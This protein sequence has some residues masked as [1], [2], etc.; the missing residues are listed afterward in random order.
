MATKGGGYAAMRKSAERYL[1][2]CHER[3]LVPKFADVPDLLKRT[4]D[5]WKL[6]NRN[7]WKLL[8]DHTMVN[9]KTDRLIEQCAVRPDFD[10]GEMKDLIREEVAGYDPKQYDRVYERMQRELGDNPEENMSSARQ[11]GLRML[12]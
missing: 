9:Q 3:G 4:P 8:I 7:Y 11:Y 12:L 10:F 5:G 6:L 1:A 2:L